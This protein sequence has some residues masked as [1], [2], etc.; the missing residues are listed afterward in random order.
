M[1]NSI[2]RESVISYCNYHI[3]NIVMINV[4]DGESRT[5]LL[6]DQTVYAVLRS[7]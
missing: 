4:R 7:R 2:D 6:E 3:K 1:L 5:C